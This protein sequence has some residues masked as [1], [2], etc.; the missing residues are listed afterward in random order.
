MQPVLF[1]LPAFPLPPL[2]DELRL[3]AISQLEARDDALM[4]TL[5]ATNSAL[6]RHAGQ[7]S[8]L[9]LAVEDVKHK[10]E[11][12]ISEI[13]DKNR[14]RQ[15]RSVFKSGDRTFTGGKFASQ[16]ISLQSPSPEN[17]LAFILYNCSISPQPTPETNVGAEISVTVVPNWLAFTTV[18]AMDKKRNWFAK[19]WLEYDGA[20]FYKQDLEDLQNLNR[21]LVAELRKTHQERKDLNAQMQEASKESHEISATLNDI[22]LLRDFLKKA[23]FPLTDFTKLRKAFPLDDFSVLKSCV[24]SG[25]VE[26]AAK[27]MACAP[28]TPIVTKEQPTTSAC[29]EPVL[30][31]QDVPVSPNNTDNECSN[32]HEFSPARFNKPTWCDFCKRFIKNPFGKQGFSC[33]KCD[34]RIHYKCLELAQATPCNPETQNSL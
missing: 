10:L 5:K 23:T 27:P 21:T 26:C 4:K 12:V 31:P 11:K 22:H 3:R 18:E 19:I 15:T 30:K 7:L 25:T 1:K 8:R 9:N 29:R 24:L 17:V 2:F 13:V 32:T 6:D 20:E 16:V 34:I 14:T 33:S 28:S